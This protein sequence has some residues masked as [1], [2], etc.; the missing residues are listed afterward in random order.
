VSKSPFLDA[1]KGEDLSDLLQHIAWTETLRP[2]LLRER[3]NYTKMLVNAT[4]GTPVQIPASSGRAAVEI[5]KEQ[6]AGKIYGIDYI[7][8][9]VEGVLS[10]GARGVAELRKSGVNLPWPQQR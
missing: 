1:A 9:L 2:A 7:V 5:S 8:E 6:L 10:K 3:D 4:L